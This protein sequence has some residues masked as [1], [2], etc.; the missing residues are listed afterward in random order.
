VAARAGARLLPSLLELGGSDPY[1]LLADA[2]LDR[3]VQACVTS[4]LLDSGQS[5]IAA[6]RFIAVDPVHDAFVERL[7][8][9]LRE[10]VLG[11][12]MDE[13]TTV[14]PMARPDLRDAIHPQVTT[15]IAAGATLRLGGAVPDRAGAWYPPPC[16][17]TFRARAP[18][19][20]K[21]CSGPSRPSFEPATRPTRSLS[22]TTRRTDSARPCSRRTWPEDARSP[23]AS[24]ERDS[25]ASTTSS[26]PTPGSLS[27][28]SSR[29]GT[30]AGRLGLPR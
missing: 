23:S 9:K 7:E 18:R 15:T 4:R 19:P 8:V 21:S 28:E 16:S 10:A 27:A 11:D 5:C 2:D 3:A 14:G 20:A 1:V 30:P 17:S 26:V 6:K 24:S 25:A 13:T 22:P 12:P 29:A